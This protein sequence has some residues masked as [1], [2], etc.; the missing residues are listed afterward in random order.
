MQFKNETKRKNKAL[1]IIFCLVLIC[2]WSGAVYAQTTDTLWYN[3]N[4]QLAL[5]EGH[6]KQMVMT[7]LSSMPLAF[8]ENQGQ[9]GDKTLFKANAGGA[10]FYFCNNEVAYLFVRDTDELLEDSRSGSDRRE[11]PD[12]FGKFDRPMYKNESLLIKAQFIGANPNPEMIGIDRLSHNNN[13]FYGNDPS[14]WCTDVPNYSAIVYKDIY[15]GIDLKYYGDGK[16]MKYDFIVNPGADISQIQIRYDGVDAL[17]VTHAGDLQAQTQFGLIHEKV[18]YI[19]Q[20]VGGVQTEITG[21]YEIK[22][23]GVFGFAVIG[24]YNPDYPLIIDP[25]L[26]YSTYLGGHGKDYGYGI[27]VDGSGSAYVTGYTTSRD[28]PTINPYDGTYNKKGDVFVTKLSPAGNSLTYSTYLGGGDDDRCW[29]ITVDGS[30]NAYVT[31]ATRSSDFPMANPYDNSLDSYWDAFV[32]K[33]SPGGNSLVYSTYLGGNI[34]DYGEGIAVDAG[35]S[36]YVTGQTA[37]SDF[38]MVNPYDGS[39]GGDRDGFVSKL[40]PG[41]NSLVYSTYLGGGGIDYGYDIAVDVDG[42]AFVTGHT[43]SSDFTM[44]NP[45]DGSLGGDRDGFVTKLSPGGNS[46]VYSTYLGG[47][48]NDGSYGIAIDGMGCAYVIGGTFSSDFPTVNPYDGSLGGDRD[49]FV[50]KL[51]PTGNSLVYSTYLGGFSD[52]GGIGIAVDASE[53]A[54]VT[55][56]TNSSDFPTVDPFEGSLS[57]NY[58]VFVTKLSP[59]GSSLT[60]STYLGGRASDIGYGIAIDGSGCA[61]VTGYTRSRDFPTVNPYDGRLNG[62]DAFVAKLTAGGMLALSTE[63]IEGEP[64]SIPKSYILN[65]NYPNPFNPQTTISYSLPVQSDV[66]VHIYNLLGQKVSTLFKGN[67]QAGEH[68][69]TWDASEFPSGVYF[70]RVETQKTVRSIKMTL[71]K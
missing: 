42:S 32:T 11:K 53:S 45:Y 44:L 31:G 70:A 46:L 62:Y 19:Y 12:M 6:Q 61:Y 36:A 69:V 37:S 20:E 5:D 3:V 24:G 33:L 52:D 48:S 59:T 41:G 34:V 29:G 60:Y 16:S 58:D 23:S 18:P 64:G 14:K 39:L 35:G 27:A 13:Y 49:G 9:F 1:A 10:T 63:I 71:M 57:G 56:W 28:F 55:G 68:S 66:S 8:T 38:P 30:G 25:E 4:A 15:P 67:Q 7:N 43:V 22:E 26:V 54:Y 65:Q 50:T 21:Y 2:A 47:V 17:S 40:S 51:S